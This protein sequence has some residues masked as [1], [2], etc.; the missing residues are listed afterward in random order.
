MASA[1]GRPAPG[2]AAG[3]TPYP[4]AFEGYR[5]LVVV[6]IAVSHVMGAVNWLPPQETLHAIRRASFFSVEFL[7]VV[8]GFLLFLPVVARGGFG[9]VRAYA[10]R[11][12]ARI[13]PAYVMS[14][15]ATLLVAVA[16]D[17]PIPP[18]ISAV[19]VFGIHLLFLQLEFNVS[20]FGLNQVYWYL[21]IIVVFYVLLPFIANRYLRHPFA[22]LA[23]AVAIVLGWRLVLQDHLTYIQF[24]QFPLFAGDFAIGMT[25]GWFFMR[26]WRSPRREQLAR[27]AIAVS[28]LALV[29]LLAMLYVVGRERITGTIFFF[30]ESPWLALAIPAAF[31]IVMGATSLMPP[32]AQW[33]LANR[34]A[35]WLGEVSYGVFLY[36][37]L[38]IAIVVKALGF[39]A[40]Q[41]T[42]TFLEMASIVIP[43][44]LVVGWLSTR[45][46][47]EPVRRWAR[48]LYE[49]SAP[50]PD[51]AATTLTAS[52]RSSVG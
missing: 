11:R 27:H 8:S 38:V 44:S 7:F 46:V 47:E 51:Q 5:G 10:I 20:G 23:V 43:V 37:A 26:A 41:Q 14:L 33:P 19:H 6:G 28:S 13:M 35:R 31:A 9:S 16:I 40:D 39:T 49:P 3:R 45:Y 17:Y 48:S 15:V 21:S 18:F 12:A 34:G 22:G 24:I 32:W 25:A 50:G 29:I 30:G 52:A 42:S 2:P 36:H 4:P 1:E